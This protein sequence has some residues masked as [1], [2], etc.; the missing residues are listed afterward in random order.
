MEQN[1]LMCVWQVQKHFIVILNE[2]LYNNSKL[3]L[4]RSSNCCSC[5]QVAVF[6]G[7][8]WI[9]LRDKSPM[10]NRVRGG[11]TGSKIPQ[12]RVLWNQTQEQSPFKW[13]HLKASKQTPCSNNREI[14]SLSN[15]LL[16]CPPFQSYERSSFS[17]NCPLRKFVH[18]QGSIQA[19]ITTGSQDYQYQL[20]ATG[21]IWP[22]N[23]SDRGFG[24]PLTCVYGNVWRISAS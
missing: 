2:G 8:A 7:K 9:I 10:P 11:P 22:G 14:S 3:H 21:M 12:D 16:P 20:G 17:P 18:I 24:S 1:I 5:K 19:S 13:L 15:P 4:K 6:L 23:V